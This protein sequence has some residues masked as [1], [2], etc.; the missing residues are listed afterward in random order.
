MVI[1]N[2]N[3]RTG[4]A[5]AR[6]SWIPGHPGL[7]SRNLSQKQNKTKIMTKTNEKI[8]QPN[9]KNPKPC[10]GILCIL[11]VSMVCCCI[12]RA[13]SQRAPSKD[14]G[15]VWVLISYLGG[16]N[17]TA[18]QIHYLNLP[19]PSRGWGEDGWR[20]CCCTKA[21]ASETPRTLR[22]LPSVSSVDHLESNKHARWPG[23]WAS[24]QQAWDQLLCRLF[25]VFWF[26]SFHIRS[27]ASF[28]HWGDVRT[29]SKFTKWYCYHWAC[30]NS[31]NCEQ[32]RL[33]GPRGSRVLFRVR[34]GAIH[35]VGAQYHPPLG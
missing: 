14:R 1:Y 21:L 28:K 5:E 16:L 10:M 20:R 35:C 22:N 31:W 6:G 19:L 7:H 8:N 3:P 4:E 13:R 11:A 25:V 15:R 29:A 12:M 17:M 30:W 27:M 33:K 18:G 34:N 23:Q 26:W 2:C 9:K 24:A 32:T